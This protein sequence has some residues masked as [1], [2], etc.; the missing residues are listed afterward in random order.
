MESTI[1]KKSSTSSTSSGAGWFAFGLG[2]LSVALG[3]IG[4]FA[5]RRA[6]RSIG[7]RNHPLLFRLIGLRE[8][9]SGFGIL[10][11][12]TPARSGWL[13]S[14]VG[15]DAVDLTL[16]GTAF[17]QSGSRRDRLGV[18]TGAV[19]GVAI[20]DTLGALLN[21]EGRPIHAIRSITVNREPKEL[22]EA[23]RNLSNL[24]NFMTNIQSV[25]PIDNIHSHWV[26]QSP[27]GTQVEWDSEITEDVPNERIAWRT[28]QDAEV[29][30]AGSVQFIPASGGRGTVVQVTLDYIPPAGRLGKIGAK[31]A[32]IFGRAPE[33][34]MEADL[35]RFEQWIETGFVTTTQGQPMGGARSL[36]SAITLEAN[37]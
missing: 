35:H 9:A 33:Q 26:A 11:E 12:R 28:T 24:P 6:A 10:T 18:A 15:G 16:L 8:L 20:L 3:L 13:W 2:W 5:P 27:V 29:S 34:Q 25:T 32:S 37:R 23:W 7:T 1:N 31:V 14:R 4:I 36:A 21:M 30:H 22:Y 17:T 19:A